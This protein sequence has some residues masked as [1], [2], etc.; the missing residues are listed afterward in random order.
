VRFAPK[1]GDPT[2]CLCVLSPPSAGPSLPLILSLL[3]YTLG[4]IIHHSPI[5]SGVRH[6]TA[7]NHV[8]QTLSAQSKQHLRTPPRLCFRPCAGRLSSPGR[9][10]S[11]T[12]L[13]TSTP[14]LHPRDPLLHRPARGV[15]GDEQGW[16]PWNPLVPCCLPTNNS[17]VIIIRLPARK[18]P[19]T[20]RGTARPRRTAI[21][22]PA[23]RHCARYGWTDAAA[24]S[25]GRRTRSVPIV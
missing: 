21:F 15:G 20:Q 16:I 23:R 2:R 18:A 1:R 9:A 17:R 3:S 10:P 14:T 24:G 25:V 22:I 13:F 19:C 12:P 6:S 11:R 7:T 5:Q 4:D 8:Q